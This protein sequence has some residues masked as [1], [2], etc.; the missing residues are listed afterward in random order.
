MH[1]HRRTLYVMVLGL[2]VWLILYIMVFE[3]LDYLLY[4]L[5]PYFVWV[6]GYF[7]FYFIVVSLCLV[8]LYSSSLRCFP[9]CFDFLITFPCVLSAFP[10]CLCAPFFHCQFVKLLFVCVT[11]QPALVFPFQFGLCLVVLDFGFSLCLF[12]CLSWIYFLVLTISC[13]TT[14]KPYHFC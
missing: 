14:C 4:F 12:V 13:L 7:L 8:L 1:K 11:F 3:L 5:L 9:T 10:S 2:S 6:A